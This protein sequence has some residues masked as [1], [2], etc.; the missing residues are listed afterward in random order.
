MSKK[1]DLFVK[2]LS[3][4][5]MIKLY[6]ANGTVPVLARKAYSDLYARLDKLGWIDEYCAWWVQ[7]QDM[8]L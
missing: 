5:R 2:T 3:A 7:M 6:E 4:F 1:V 8:G